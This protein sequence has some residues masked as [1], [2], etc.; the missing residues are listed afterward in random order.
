[1]YL[2]LKYLNHYQIL[3][4]KFY[5]LKNTWKDKDA[6]DREYKKLGSLFANN[7][8]KYAQGDNAQYKKFGPS[9]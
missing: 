3:I 9:Q 1:M 4:I 2:D 7:F 5:N 6:Y 8:N